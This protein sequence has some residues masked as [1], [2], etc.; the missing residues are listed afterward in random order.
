LF[1]ELRTYRPIPGRHG[2]LLAHTKNNIVPLYHKYGFKPQGMWMVEIGPAV[3]NLVQLWEWP[4]LEA[5]MKA[6]EGLHSD[7]QYLD[8]MKEIAESVGALTDTLESVLLRGV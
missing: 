3:G 7:P 5:R 4:D 1:H 8:R 2:E 6:M